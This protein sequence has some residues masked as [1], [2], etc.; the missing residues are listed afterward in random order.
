MSVQLWFSEP[1][2]NFTPESKIGAFRVRAFQGWKL[3]AGALLAW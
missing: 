2:H 1:N 3:L